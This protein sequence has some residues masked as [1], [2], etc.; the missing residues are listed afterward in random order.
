M[1]SLNLWI[2]FSDEKAISWRSVFDFVY[3]SG[4][5]MGEAKDND[6]YEEELI[7]Y[8]EEEVKAADEVAVKATGDGPKK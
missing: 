1:S 8:E 2:L 7:D 4:F 5:R 3:G 6:A